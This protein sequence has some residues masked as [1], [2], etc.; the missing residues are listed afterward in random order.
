[1]EH[2]K[3]ITTFRALLCSW[4]KLGTKIKHNISNSSFLAVRTLSSWLDWGMSVWCPSSNIRVLCTTLWKCMLPFFKY[5]QFYKNSL[6]IN[7]EQYFLYVYSCMV[8]AER[9]A[10][11]RIVSC[12]FVSPFCLSSLF[13]IKPIRKILGGSSKE[14][15]S[16]FAFPFF[17]FIPS[18][19][20]FSWQR[21]NAASRSSQSIS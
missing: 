13:F 2:V 3:L 8:D 15:Y 9:V 10:K 21:R 5:L 1:M 12:F 6:D 7:R 17:P 4:A 11:K 19:H 16:F 20:S 18:F 14:L